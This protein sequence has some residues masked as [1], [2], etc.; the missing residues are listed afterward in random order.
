MKQYDDLDKRMALLEQKIDLVLNNHLNHM[1]KDIAW[2][3]K[4]IFG[5]AVVVI[6]EAGVIIAAFNGMM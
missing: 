4:I 5:A 3:K 1:E 2:I 6:A